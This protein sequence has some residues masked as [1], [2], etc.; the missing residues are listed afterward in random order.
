M[1]ILHK[2]K[3]LVEGKVHELMNPEEHQVDITVVPDDATPS[4]IEGSAWREYLAAAT[5]NMFTF[6]MNAQRIPELNQWLVQQGIA[7]LEIK[8][9]HSLEA[10]FLSLTND[11]VTAN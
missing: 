3:K 2:G 4:K 9:K 7:V 1:L 8:S 10:Y 6:K 11:T 5:K